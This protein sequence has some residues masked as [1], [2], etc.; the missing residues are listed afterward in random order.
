MV[1]SVASR[2]FRQLRK[3]GWQFFGQAVNLVDDRKII[4]PEDARNIAVCLGV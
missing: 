1:S 2:L 3:Q 4:R